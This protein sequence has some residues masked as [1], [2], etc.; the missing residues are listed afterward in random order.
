M[1]EADTPA[2]R[3]KPAATVIIFRRS[4]GGPDSA[5]PP[6]LLMVQR[7]QG[8]RFA[9]GAAVFPG[10]R[11]DPGDRALAARIAPH[12]DPEVT[13]ARIAGV[14]E[15]LEETGLAIALS[16]PVSA[17]EAADARALAVAEGGLAPVL[18][19]FGWA[20]R[21]DTLTPFARWCP[22]Q[23]NTFDTRFF[24]HDLGSGGVELEVDATENTRLFWTTAAD[25]LALADRGA[26][27][28]IFPTKANLLRLTKFAS[29]SEACAEAA[30]IPARMITPR[31]EDR[32]G[33]P[34]L[35]IPDDLGYPVTEQLLS[36]IR[37]G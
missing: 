21:L 2:P 34:Y 31:I 11:I 27:H 4:A 10:G 7:A 20:L 24:L 37:R 14:R 12:D 6:E 23:D 32:H 5:G 33:E 19:R 17:G 28:V 22:M 35:V 15:T 9:G 16:R 8:M 18:E 1:S 29:F 26:F 13:A 3:V 30:A 25:A 36:A